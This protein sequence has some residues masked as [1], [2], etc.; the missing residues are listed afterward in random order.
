MP[1]F[2]ARSFLITFLFVGTICSMVFF[3][4]K[5]GFPKGIDGIGDWAWGC[6]S[7][8]FGT[9]LIIARDFL[10][11]FFGIIL[12][13]FFVSGGIMLM[14]TGTRRFVGQP[15]HYLRFALALLVFFFALFPVVLGSGDLRLRLAFVTSVNTVLFLLGLFSI[16]GQREKGFPEWLTAF[17]FGFTALTSASRAYMGFT[18][19]GI[20]ANGHDGS[21]V[22]QIYLGTFAVAL[23]SASLGFLLMATRKLQLRLEHAASRDNLTGAYNRAAFCELFSRELSRSARHGLPMLVLI[24]DID[25]FKQVNDRHGHA[26]GDRVLQAF[27]SLAT[28]ELRDADVFCRYGGEEF[29]ILLPGTCEQEAL[30]VAERI[31]ENFAALVSPGIVPATISIGLMASRDGHGQMADFIDMADRALY[32][33]KRSGKNRVVLASESQAA[34]EP[35]HAS[36]RVV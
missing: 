32:L 18:G 5:R 26:M 14:I 4:L 33:A 28:Q 2:D 16:L 3:A 20:P 34:N 29:A 23:I 31:R 17:M 9:V 35:L 21:L 11:P 10:S 19:H 27:S 22:Q 30:V 24:L 6:L 15:A 13:N 8:V 7:V 25:D 1:N 12:A 36:T